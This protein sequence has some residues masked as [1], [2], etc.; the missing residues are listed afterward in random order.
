[1]KSITKEIYVYTL[2]IGKIIE[3]NLS[4]IIMLKTSASTGVQGPTLTTI[5]KDARQSIIAPIAMGGRNRSI[6]LKITNLIC[7]NME[8]SA[9]NHTVLTIIQT[10]IEDLTCR[11]GLKSFQK[12]E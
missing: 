4:C 9:Q 8:I 11:F 6:I 1:M 7:V 3:E 5:K 10:K 12:L 2:I